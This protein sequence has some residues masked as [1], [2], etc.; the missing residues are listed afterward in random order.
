M[1]STGPQR[2]RE[3]QAIVDELLSAE[4]DGYLPTVQEKT[5][6]DFK[7]EAGRRIRD[8]LE[9]GQAQNQVA[10]TKLAD[11][12]ACFAN[13]P[14]G[15][16]V[17]VGVEDETGRILGTALDEEWLRQAIHRAV[18]VAPSVEAHNVGGQRVLTIFVAESPTVVE[19][20]SDRIRWRVG[21]HC[22]PVDRSE[23]WVHRQEVLN[24]DVMA[25]ESPTG[26]EAI[27]HGSWKLLKERLT[28]EGEPLDRL[29]ALQRIGVMRGDRLSFAGELLLTSAGRILLELTTLDLPGGQVTNRVVPQASESLLEQ[30]ETVQRALDVANDH[31][32]LAQGLTHRSIRRVP[33][34]AAREAILNGL[35]HRDWDSAESTRIRWFD[36]DSMLEVRSPGG[37]TG[38]VTS[39]NILAERHARYPALADVFR[40]LGMVEKEGLGVDRMYQ[41]MIVLGHRTP[42]I[43]EVAGPHVETTLVGGEPV[44]GV[45]EFV[46]AIRPVE[47][48]R[49]PRLALILEHLLHHAFIDVPTAGRILHRD[50]QG[51]EVAMRVATQTSVSSVPLLAPYADVWILSPEAS[52]LI[53]HLKEVDPVRQ[54]FRRGSTNPQ[55][56]QKVIE[57]WLTTHSRMTTRDLA[58]LGGVSRNTA[59]KALMDLEGLTLEKFGSG[60]TTAYRRLN[61]DA[62][63]PR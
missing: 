47:R 56:L 31:V 48:Q 41:T 13:T 58:E 9:P 34:S 43:A 21:D 42:Y 25:A 19:D 16:V 22:A 27:T 32:V 3:L 6:L 18:D 2:R 4:K 54:F 59:Q 51:A 49:D 24:V 57:E 36:V 39:E 15:G 28:Q 20:T 46:D 52:E 8:Q 60:R 30:L 62:V 44:E 14:G 63:V 1:P 12:V 29:Q 26:P 17:V 35:I 38:G 53:A 23:W 7:E 11:E 5:S 61:S 50:R 55:D 40:A 10:A 37:F 45:V 33:Y